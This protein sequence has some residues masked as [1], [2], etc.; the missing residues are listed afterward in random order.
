MKVT[1]LKWEPIHGFGGAYEISNTGQVYSHRK[2]RVL[3]LSTDKF[4]YLRVSLQKHNRKDKKLYFVHRLVAEAFIP[5]IENKPYVNHKDEQKNNNC[6]EN[7]EWCSH[8]ENMNYGTRNLR[9]A[10]SNTNNPITSKKVL[11]V[12]TSK[13]FPSINEAQRQLHIYA[14][15]ITKCCKGK[16]PHAGGF[17]WTFIN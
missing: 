6:A 2:N 13:V 5:N 17:S 11:C 3:K 14:T 12:E 7:L 4:G 16:R 1:D 8:K 15:N 10:L 9:I